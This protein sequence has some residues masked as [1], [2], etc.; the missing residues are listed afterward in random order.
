[1][2]V[3]QFKRKAVIETY[4]HTVPHLEY[5]EKLSLLPKGEKPSPE[6]A[7][8][9]SAAYGIGV[10]QQIACRRCPARLATR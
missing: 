2:P 10:R 4:H 1:M 5:D 6:R 8:A 3:L 9:G 7:T